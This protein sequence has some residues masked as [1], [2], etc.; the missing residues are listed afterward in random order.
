MNAKPKTLFQD[1]KT[2]NEEM[3]GTGTDKLGF[4]SN[5]TME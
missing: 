2:L 4:T 1:P 5:V 3:T